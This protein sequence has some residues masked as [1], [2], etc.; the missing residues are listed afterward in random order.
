MASE[1][2]I[3]IERLIKRYRS[4]TALD[5]VDRQ[6]AARSIVGLVGRNGAG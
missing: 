4:V 3:E 6:L 5:E 2:P 1:P